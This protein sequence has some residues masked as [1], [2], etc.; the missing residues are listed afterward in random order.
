MSLRGQSAG[1]GSKPR[2]V[3]LFCS[4][5]LACLLLAACG[6]AQTTKASGASTQSGHGRRVA[7]GAAASAKRTASPSTSRSAPAATTAPA[8]GTAQPSVGHG[9]L[10]TSESEVIFLQF[11]EGAGGNLTGSMYDDSLSGSPPNE[12]VDTETSSFTGTVAGGQ[13]T[14]DLEGQS[15]PVFGEMTGSTIRLE[16][17]QS[18]GGLAEDTFTKA[19]PTQY[20]ASLATLQQQAS[21]DNQSV[22]APTNPAALCTQGCPSLPAVPAGYYSVGVFAPSSASDLVNFDENPLEV[23]FAV[24]GSISSLAYEIGSPSSGPTQLYQGG[25]PTSGCVTDPGNDTGL[26]DVA[27]TA[28]GTGIWLVQ[29]DES[30]PT[31]ASVLQQ[32]AQ[33]EAQEQQAIDQAASSV[34]SDTSTLGDDANTLGDDV[35]TLGDDLNT[36]SDDITTEQG[37]YTNFKGDLSDNNDACGD[38]SG[39]DQ[40]AQTVASDGQTLWDDSHSG[41]LT[42]I[43]SFQRDIANARSD[44]AAYEKAQALLPSYQTA[45]SV[46]PLSSTLATAQAAITSSVSHAN[47]DIDQANEA[48]VQAYAL[49]NKA[50]QTGHCGQPA[51]PSA[52]LRHVAP[53]GS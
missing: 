26:T 52:P 42:D 50:D 14:L 23:C 41:L 20:D 18:D 40:D 12:S 19:T 36:I 28:T 16:V 38:I 46:P 21:S 32:Q 44:W 8:A 6:T 2:V 25:T 53:A 34:G 30:T 31:E 45:N 15:A 35:N 27:I 39:L 13:I 51:S 24:S 17:P 4:L 43:V 3:A 5:A 33:Q 10:G 1:R 22:I 29:V 37:D 47:A 48:T 49:A 11:N 7:L 9:F